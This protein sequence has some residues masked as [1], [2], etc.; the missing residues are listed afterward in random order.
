MEKSSISINKGC[1]SESRVMVDSSAEES[2][3]TLYFDDLLNDNNM[4]STEYFDH[5]KHSLTLSTSDNE[6]SSSRLSLVPD[7]AS[8]AS[9]VGSSLKTSC[10]RLNFK[11]RRSCIVLN[12]GLSMASDDSL[13]DTASSPANSPKVFFFFF[14]PGLV[15]VS[16]F[17]VLLNSKTNQFTS[18]F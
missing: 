9:M 11:K 4:I 8:S 2:G 15:S 6:V 16:K 12:K 13:E 10:R 1:S 17:S 3:W 5:G 14:L 7:A 18:I